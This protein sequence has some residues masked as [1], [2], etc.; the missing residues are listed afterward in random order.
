MSH[1]NKHIYFIVLLGYMKYTIYYALIISIITTPLC[2]GFYT[3]TP[4]DQSQQ[5]QL[6]QTIDN[7]STNKQD[8]RHRY[9]QIFFLSQSYP[10][11][12]KIGYLLTSLQDHLYNKI[13]TRKADADKRSEPSKQ[14]FIKK[15]ADRVIN[16]RALPVGCTGKYEMLDM[17]GY[18]HDIPT[19][20]IAATRAKEGTC[21]LSL[22]GNGR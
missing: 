18:V 14:E 10:Q 5:S 22:P 13:D 17:V 20:L 6:I 3:P 2:S 21:R 1:D 12:T 19:S 16:E 15:Y 8:A 11:D 7:L 4:E 9:S